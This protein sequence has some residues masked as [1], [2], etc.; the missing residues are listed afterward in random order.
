M[1][2]S[3]GTDERLHRFPHGAEVGDTEK[4][5]ELTLRSFWEEPREIRVTVVEGGHGSGDVRMLRDPLHCVAPAPWSPAWPRIVPSRRVDPY[6][7][8]IS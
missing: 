3:P 1:D 7:H 6:G 5:A 2:P 4:R 8:G